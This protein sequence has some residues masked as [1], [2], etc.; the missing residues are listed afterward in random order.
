VTLRKTIAI[1]IK[2]YGKRV[3]ERFDQAKSM[4]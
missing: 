1:K 4:K 2:G 3:F